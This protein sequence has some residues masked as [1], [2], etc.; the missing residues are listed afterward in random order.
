MRFTGGQTERD[1]RS[2][3]AALARALLADAAAPAPGVF[4]E[5]AAAR[6]AEA[7][8]AAVLAA[9]A[10]AAPAG[11]WRLVVNAT[12]T[13]RG[14]PSATAHA[15]LGG[16]DDGS[17]V[18]REEGDAYA[19]VVS[20]TGLANAAAGAPPGAAVAVVEGAW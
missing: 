9:L 8:A 15:T 20:I 1:C 14:A 7:I 5:A 6:A 13:P 12:V 16:P 19:A 2:V 10:A 18:V 4:S 11:A 17:L 3:T